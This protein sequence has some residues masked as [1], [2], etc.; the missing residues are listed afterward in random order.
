M[1][2]VSGRVDRSLVVREDRDDT[3]VSGS[4]NTS[5]RSQHELLI[6]LGTRL[7]L[8]VLR[9]EVLSKGNPTNDHREGEID[10]VQLGGIDRGFSG[11]FQVLCGGGLQL[12]SDGSSGPSPE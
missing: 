6:W 9:V 10:A 1:G 5:C 8:V 7:Q 12:G 11:L 3:L 4:F 2:W